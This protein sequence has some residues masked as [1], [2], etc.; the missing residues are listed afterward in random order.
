MKLIFVSVEIAK[1]QRKLN[2]LNN[3]RRKYLR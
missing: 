2:I 1:N 3:L